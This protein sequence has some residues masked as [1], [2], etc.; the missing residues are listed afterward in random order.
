MMQQQA[1]LFDVM[2]RDDVPQAGAVYRGYT[3]DTAPEEAVAAFE[4][5]YHRAPDAVIRFGGILYVGP[6]RPEE[7]RRAC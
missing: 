2:V 3:G 7:V 1:R 5:R 6:V 4:Q